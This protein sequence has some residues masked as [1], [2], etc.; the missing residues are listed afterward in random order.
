[1]R[2][3]RSAVVGRGRAR[4]RGAEHE[5]EHELKSESRV[6]P[7]PNSTR[8]GLPCLVNDAVRECA[9]PATVQD[10][11]PLA[12]DVD[13]L[14]SA[15]PRRCAR[16]DELKIAHD[17]HRCAARTCVRLLC[18]TPRLDAWTAAPVYAALALAATCGASSRLISRGAVAGGRD[19]DRAGNSE[20]SVY[21][22]C[23]PEE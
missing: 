12:V 14:R 19:E 6:R 18:I 15:T 16:R 4:C 3:L 13:I 11:F 23:R 1:M 8:V 10:S 22:R 21:I 7:A 9:R 5:H 2:S 17:P 20:H